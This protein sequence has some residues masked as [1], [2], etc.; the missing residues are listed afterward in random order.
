[1]IVI[2]EYLLD[3]E[4]IKAYKDRGYRF[5]YGNE[6]PYIKPRESVGI[7]LDTM[8]KSTMDLIDTLLFRKHTVTLKYDDE[9]YTL[10]NLDEWKK[11]YQSDEDSLKM[12]FECHPIY[13]IYLDKRAEYFATKKAEK[14]EKQY[15]TVYDYIDRKDIPND[16]ELD[17]FL[18]TFGYL[19]QVDVDYTDRLSKLYTYIQLKWYLE[20]DLPYANEPMSIDVDDEPMFST[21]QFK[22]PP[23]EPPIEE[24]SFGDATYFEDFVYKN[25]E[26]SCNYY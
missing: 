8:Y 15:D 14:I 17:N 11:S 9:T 24:I 12:T 18:R 3:E 20:H 1:M 4:T 6:H 16:D 23:F 13:K 26:S 19:Y 21:I 5:A 25:T 2:S 7:L 22:I 10:S